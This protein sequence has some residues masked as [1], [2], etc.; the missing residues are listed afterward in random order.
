MINATRV[1]ELVNQLK[2]FKNHM[3]ASNNDIIDGLTNAKYSIDLNKG[4]LI[5]STV[6]FKIMYDN[7][8]IDL[9]AL[10]ANNIKY[11]AFKQGDPNFSDNAELGDFLNTN[12]NNLLIIKHLADK[13]V[14]DSN[15]NIDTTSIVWQL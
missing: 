4:E 7:N 5:I 10:I 1:S 9:S 14:T 13:H 6:I 11:Q 15:L 8:S 3:I 12:S 2:S